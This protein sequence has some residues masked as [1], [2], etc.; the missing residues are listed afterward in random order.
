MTK[1]LAN[2][3]NMKVKT[4]GR[5]IKIFA[6]IGS[7]GWGLSFCCAHIL[8]PIIKG[9][10]PILI[11]FGKKFGSYGKRP[12]KFKIEVGSATDKS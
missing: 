6:C 8:I 10:I 3:A 4:I 2:G 11:I 12:N 5:N 9:H 1:P 7:V